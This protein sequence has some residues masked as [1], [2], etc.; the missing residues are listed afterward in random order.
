MKEVILKNNYWA[1]KD[2]NINKNKRR[3]RYVVKSKKLVVL[4][5]FGIVIAIVLAGQVV[6][7][8]GEVVEITFWHMKRLHAELQRS[9]R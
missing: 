5:I 9:K 8:A 4:I 6:A 3:I 2:F 7:A 1:P